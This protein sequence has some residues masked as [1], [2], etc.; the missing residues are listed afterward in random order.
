[1]ACTFDLAHYERIL[2]SALQQGYVF[3][4]F[5]DYLESGQDKEQTILLRHDV[6]VS[7]QLAGQMASLEYRLGVY[8]TFF[9]RVHATR[10]NPFDRD[11]YSVLKQL[12]E[13]GFE[14]A[15]HQEASLKSQEREKVLQWLR[16]E[17]VVLESIL[18]SP[19]VG[20]STHLPKWIN[21]E[22]DEDMLEVCELKYEAG[23]ATFNSQGTVFVSDSNQQWRNGCVCQHLGK[24][25]K[26]YV[27]IHPFWWFPTSA[28]AE[29]IRLSLVKGD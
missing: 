1:M 3:Y 13:H 5:R 19:V 4:T 27:N 15:L 24:I 2:T 6:D 28:S 14:V 11:N 22:I 26:L 9:I 29:E 21:G 12:L 16:R 17:K 20:V 8:S 25:S 7:L 10:Y 23:G 18:G